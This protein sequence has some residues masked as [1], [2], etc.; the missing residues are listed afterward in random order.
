VWRRSRGILVTALFVVGCAL[1]VVALDKIPL[2]VQQDELSDI[3]DGYSI[4]ETGSDRSGIHFPFVVRAFG[5][6]D[7]RPPLYAW[8]AAIPARFAGFSIVGGR[9]PS[10]ILGCAALFLVFAF[11]TRL[12]G[13]DFGLITL[14]L[15]TFSPWFISFSRVAHG[16]A[17]LPPFFVILILYLW[18]R[19]YAHDF[20]SRWLAALGLVVGLSTTAYQSTR[21]MALLF[22]MCIV[23]FV[24]KH[25]Q[26]RAREVVTFGAATFVGA[27]SQII[28]LAAEPAHFV[29]RSHDTVLTAGSAM[30]FIAG[31]LRNAG[32]NLG[33]RY[34]FVPDMTETYM[35]SA[36][37]LPVEILLFYPGLIFVAFM[38][39]HTAERF[40]NWLYAALVISI[41]P[42]A[43]SNQNP[44]SLRASG[45]A[46]LAPLFSAATVL[47]VR[48]WVK[49]RRLPVALYDALFGASVIVSAVLVGF[50]YLHSPRARGER[51]QSEITLAAKSVAARQKSF[52][53]VYFENSGYQPYL[54]LVAFGGM[55]PEE[56]MAAPKDMGAAH[57]RMD[58]VRRIGRY[59]FLDSAAL[60]AQAVRSAEGKTNDLF[61]ARH[62]VPGTIAVDS[63]SSVWNRYYIMRL[64][65]H[66]GSY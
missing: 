65:A 21:L 16:G 55:T 60:D 3:Y 42:A 53:R 15:A 19:A 23:A 13:G 62:L 12:G 33:W 8:L 57:G 35:T 22:A 41:L 49:T 25:G 48:D 11:A 58:D 47:A 30:G 66:T 63:A 59:F 64:A 10:A 45:V 6:A 36:R 27:L 9:L 29:A 14:V 17:I 50:L 44:H 5:E 52:D 20:S 31:V 24:L 46:I 51:M 40:R 7:Y 38:R 39:G 43:L 18:E 4:A 32:I 26:R 37:L 54:Y 28:V 56:Y 1:R 2:P 34:L 61:V